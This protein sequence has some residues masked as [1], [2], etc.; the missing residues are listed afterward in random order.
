MASGAPFTATY[1][2]IPVIASKAATLALGA[3]A[4]E[5]G[6]TGDIGMPSRLEKATRYSLARLTLSHM[7]T[8]PA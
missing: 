3:W 4:K 7:R 6:T 2:G 8:F 1:A 5:S